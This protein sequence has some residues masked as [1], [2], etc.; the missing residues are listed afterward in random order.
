MPS[1]CPGMG[2]PRTA[3]LV[4]V[5]WALGALASQ[6]G[7]KPSQQ[8]E[9]IPQLS[10]FSQEE[11]GYAAP[12]APPRSQSPKLN[13]PITS[14]HIFQGQ[15]PVDYLFE[16]FPVQQAQSPQRILLETEIES[17]P[18]KAIPLQEEVQPLPFPIEQKEVE[19]PFHP[20]KDDGFSQQ[21]QKEKMEHP[22]PE[23]SSYNQPRH[24]PQDPRFG[25]WGHR[26][27]GFPPGRPN[28]DN[29]N[30]ICLPDRKHVVYGPWNLPQTGHSHLSRQGNALNFLET[31]YTRCCH[32]KT[33][34][35]DCA[36]SVWADALFRF[37]ESE[38]SVKTR[39]YSCCWLRGEARLSCFQ[40]NAPLPDYKLLQGPCPSHPPRPSSSLE[41]SF[42]P[43]VPTPGNIRNICRFRRYRSIPRGLQML[44]DLMPQLRAVAQLEG[45]FKRCCHQGDNHTCARQAWEDVLD[46][47]CDEELAIKTHHHVCCHRSPISARD[48]CFARHAPYPNYDRDILTVDLSRITPDTMSQ[49]CGHRKVLTKHKQIPGL[50][51][52]M[53]ARC[54][55]LPPADQGACA[56]EEKSAFIE[57]LCGSRRD[58]WRDSDYCCEEKPGDEQTNCFNTHYLRNV[59]LVAGVAQKPKDQ[60]EAGTTELPPASPTPE[61]KGE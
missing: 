21:E 59:A 23:S 13:D 46:H 7:P 5:I 19:S 57:D 29:I 1:P 52:N 31:G 3:A 49:L 25:G 38:F 60:P 17:T 40:E 26:L 43:G 32:L 16:D 34:R 45:K 9:V 58:S 51:R 36:M 15:E 54:C 24:C 41:L 53:T 10:I 37:C 42:P 14:Q 28:P 2:S 47:Y 56:E 48:D 27:D 35:L 55:E 6:G 8:R 20:P 4:F 12:P 44:E 30:Q 39:A 33:D 61:H 50:I 22:S 11:V 18:N